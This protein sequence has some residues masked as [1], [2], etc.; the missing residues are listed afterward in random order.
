MAS[1]NHGPNSST[2]TPLAPS[3]AGILLP[4]SPLSQGP[5]PES[6]D[7]LPTTGGS[8][9]TSNWQVGQ[10]SRQQS[11]TQD[12]SPSNLERGLG[13]YL[14]STNTRPGVAQI[15]TVNQGLGPGIALPPPSLAIYEPSGGQYDAR[16]RGDHSP[17]NQ[18]GDPFAGSP[19]GSPLRHADP[20]LPRT[21]SQTGSPSSATDR[22]HTNAGGTSQA[23]GVHSTHWRP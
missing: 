20:N 1:E 22:F 6:G 12:A 4:T 7:L 23:P 17:Q 15:N 16:P 14:P 3:S 9:S 21:R 10:G 11:R 2:N 5:S 13:G 18:H 8:I 19:N